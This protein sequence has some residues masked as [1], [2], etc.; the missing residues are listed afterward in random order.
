[1]SPPKRAP[2]SFSVIAAPSVRPCCRSL[3]VLPCAGRARVV[4][5]EW[6]TLRAGD[7]RLCANVGVA[8]DD[9]GVVVSE[10]PHTY[11]VRVPC[12]FLYVTYRGVDD[13]L[14]ERCVS[15]HMLTVDAPDAPRSQHSHDAYVIAAPRAR[16]PVVDIGTCDLV[17]PV[18][19]VSA[20]MQR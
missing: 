5:S 8:D 10:L 12:A 7:G 14:T 16:H 11:A 20:T 13:C 19:Y 18:A 2:V 6:G 3:S 9:Y 15:V 4:G 17:T 1:V